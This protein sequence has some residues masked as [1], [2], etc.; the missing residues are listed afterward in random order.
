MKRVAI[1]GGGLSGVAAAYQLAR[2]GAAECTLFESSARLG[3]IVETERVATAD[4][5]FVIECG[6]DSWITE[7][8]WA[9]ELAIELGL[10][11]EI[12]P[13]ND[14]RRRTY[15]FEDRRLIPI[16]DGMRLMVPSKW[17]PIMESPLFSWQARLA[18]LREA[19][20][21]EELKQSALPP[22]D[23]ESIAS[24]VRRHFGNEVAETLAAPLL[25]G[26][27]GG[28][29][30]TLSVRAVM[31]AFVAMEQKHGS[32]IAALQNRG[33]AK[34]QAAAIFTSLRSGLETLI[35]RMAATLPG[36]T[37]RL[38][39]QVT[40][41]ARRGDHWQ[42]E[43]AGSKLLFDEI[44]LATPAHV[45][46]Q[47]LRPTHPDFDTL[48]AMDASSAIVVALAFTAEQAKKL[49]LPR[50]FGYL[51]LQKPRRTPP[52][53]GSDPD[54]LACTFVDQKF[55]YRA[56]EGAVLLR[57]F[58][59]GDA[60][61]AL[62]GESDAR[63]ISLAHRQIAR[64]LGPLPDPAISLVRRW[65]LSLPQ[66]AVGHLTRMEQLAALTASLPGL[67]LIGNAYHGVGLP[68][69]IRLG[70]E[71]ARRIAQGQNQR[72]S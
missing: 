59:G 50:G 30:D 55:P 5:D 63:L 9:R 19:R 65:P 1:V 24:F 71:A 21:A 53:P 13:S 54:L 26:V 42:L 10:E 49:R 44:I 70:R 58:F 22:G 18:Y 69:M 4:G 7:K 29:I 56:P 8:P 51:A 36:N 61:P 12:I 14:Q 45:T 3:G 64:A 31:P 27:F 28:S 62:L 67:H 72:R 48:L 2:D 68:D 46:R 32:L 57:G 17:A 6:P 47:L 41:L 52:A 16:P 33:T 38:D 66:Y 20:R 15:L 37:V 11:S 23:D 40:S 34:E 39:H 25:A 60:A 43:A 35:E